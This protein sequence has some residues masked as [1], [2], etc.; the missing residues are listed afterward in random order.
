MPS[1]C[2][3]RAAPTAEETDVLLN[4]LAKQDQR[5][6]D[7]WLNPWDLLGSA[8]TRNPSLPP[9]YHAAP[10]AAWTAVSR[11]MLNLDETITK[12]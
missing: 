7:G 11:V 5:L 1:V 4:L 2:A 9:G 12:E 10:L 6:A 3:S 8:P